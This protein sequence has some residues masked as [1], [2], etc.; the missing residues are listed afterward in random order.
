MKGNKAMHS[1]DTELKKKPQDPSPQ[2]MINKSKWQNKTHLKKQFKINLLLSVL[3]QILHTRS[4]LFLTQIL[5]HHLQPWHLGSQIRNHKPP[6]LPPHAHELH[7]HTHWSSDDP[8]A[9][10]TQQHK[11]SN[12]PTKTWDSN[13][14]L[15]TPQW[16]F[17]QDQGFKTRL[18]NTILAT[19][20]RLLGYS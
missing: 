11:N 2:K 9:Q 8:E 5:F 3:I 13:I 4:S 12:I 7:K 18:V 6:T 14:F 1:V 16:D 20:L 17:N 19:T 15:H 10:S